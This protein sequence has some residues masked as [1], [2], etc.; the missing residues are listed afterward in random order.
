MRETKDETM[1]VAKRRKNARNHKNVDGL[2]NIPGQFVMS[3]KLRARVE[4]K[5][6]AKTSSEHIHF[7]F[8]LFIERIR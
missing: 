1:S 3:R 2:V 8:I 4:K 7:G 6:K 5:L